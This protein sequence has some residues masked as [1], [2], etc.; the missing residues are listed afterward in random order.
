VFYVTPL[1]VVNHLLK[2]CIPFKEAKYGLESTDHMWKFWTET[3]H[4]NDKSVKDILDKS[5]QVF[6]LSTDLEECTDY[7]NPTLAR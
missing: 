3:L 4:P 1:H 2:G 6:A 5:Y 7:G